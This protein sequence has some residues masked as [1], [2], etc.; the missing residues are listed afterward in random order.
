MA[1]GLRR[2]RPAS[3]I[4]SMR[5]AVRSG[6]CAGPLVA[7]RTAAPLPGRGA[8]DDLA[9]H[10]ALLAEQLQRRRMAEEVPLL[11]CLREKVEGHLL[12]TM[13]DPVDHPVGH[14]A[15]LVVDHEL[16]EA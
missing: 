12:V 3:M 15:Q 8:V 6:T 7:G 10:V 16:L 4:S 13:T 2:A 9:G 11:H 1:R 14:A 5:R